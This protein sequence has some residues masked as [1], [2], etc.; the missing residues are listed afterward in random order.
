VQYTYQVLFEWDPFKAALNKRKHRVSFEE[1]A[2]CFQDPLALLLEDPR[3]PDRSILIGSSP[4]Q[5]LIL[6]VF[7]ERDAAVIRIVSAR[8][9]TVRERRKY[10]EGDS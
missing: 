5:R 9:A 2:E 3:Y 4:R 8:R 7:V 1:A 6:T 10:E